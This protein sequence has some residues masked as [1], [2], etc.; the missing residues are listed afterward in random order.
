MGVAAD[1]EYVQKQDGQEN[2]KRQILTTWNTASALYKVDMI[3][4]FGVAQALTRIQDTFNVSLGITTL[5]VQDSKYV[6]FQ[7]PWKCDQAFLML[8]P[9]QLSRYSG[10]I[11]L[12]CSLLCCD[13]QQSSVSLL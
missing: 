1:C 5:N 11:R 8:P 13:P 9:N 4:Y 3:P 6:D 10:G 2:A 12:E 7:S